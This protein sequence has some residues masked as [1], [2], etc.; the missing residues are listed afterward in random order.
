MD[1]PT[2]EQAV[3]SGRIT[4]LFC[5][6]HD[7]HSVC[8]KNLNDDYLEQH[9]ECKMVRVDATAENCSNCR[10]SAA[11]LYLRADGDL[12]CVRCMYVPG[13]PMDLAPVK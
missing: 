7:K 13:L 2:I 8:G 11:S 10:D 6:Q 1:K 4:G 12:L 9:K 3:K 5:I